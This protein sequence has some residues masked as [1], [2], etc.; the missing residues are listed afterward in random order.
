MRFFLNKMHLAKIKSR[1]VLNQKGSS[2]LNKVLK[3]PI[4]PGEL[5]STPSINIVKIGMRE[6]GQCFRSLELSHCC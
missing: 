4:S 1:R 5:R 6:K 2:S 3:V